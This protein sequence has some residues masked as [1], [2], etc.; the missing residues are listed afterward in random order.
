MMKDTDDE[1]QQTDEAYRLF[2]LEDDDSDDNHDS[3]KCQPQV[4]Y[5]QTHVD[6]LW[7]WSE[8]SRHHVP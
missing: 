1:I 7:S 8:T 2:V 6:R 4:D 3:D 5:Q